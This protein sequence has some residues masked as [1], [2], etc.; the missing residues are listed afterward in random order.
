MIEKK[1]I[2]IMGPTAIGKTSLSLK[3]CNFLKFEIISVDSYMVY[4]KLDVGTGKIDIIKNNK[5]K[6]NLVD[7][8][9]PID[10]YSVFK[11]CIESL[12]IIEQTFLNKKIPLFV[13]GNIMYNWFVQEYFLK[14]YY[15][16]N[17]MYRYKFINIVI[18]PT[19]KKQ[20]KLYIKKRFIEMVKKNMLEEVKYLYEKKKIK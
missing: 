3:L 14:K 10:S 15:M 5:H 20:I 12:F 1:I 11:F 19:N 17:K 13:G 7:I 9:E 18:L 6:S 4:K 8:I 2:S 16:I